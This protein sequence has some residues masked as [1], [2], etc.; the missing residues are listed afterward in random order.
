M[1]RNYERHRF[2]DSLRDNERRAAESDRNPNV[3]IGTGW[4]PD[5]S[6]K[7]RVFRLTCALSDSQD[8]AIRS[9]KHE[10]GSIPLEAVWPILKDI[11]YDLGLFIGGGG[12]VGA[13]VG[14]VAATFATGG[15]G[16]VPGAVAG[17]YLGTQAGSLCM[18]FIGLEEVVFYL[19]KAL[20]NAAE[21]YKM[22][23][24]SA[25][26]GSPFAANDFADGHVLM[27]KAILAGIV[28]YLTAGKGKLPELLQ[29]IK[30]SKKLGPQFATWVEQN[31]KILINNAELQRPNFNS[32]N[33]CVGLCANSKA[34]Q[35]TEVKIVSDD[36][37]G[38]RG[39]TQKD[40]GPAMTPKQLVAEKAKM[41]KEMAI[42]A[43]EKENIKNLTRKA[44][45]R[46][47][48]DDKLK[49]Y[50]LNPDHPLGASKAKWFDEA[51]EFNIKNSDKLAEQIVFNEASA[52]KTEVIEQGVK[53]NQVIPIQGANNKVI[54]VKFGWIRNN[55]GVVRLI[56]AIPTKK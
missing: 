44:A 1:P 5:T 52:V 39:V 37:F 9:L 15:V 7:G 47:S 32:R 23:F 41:E 10:L 38:H 50:L 28:F 30:A 53:F 2:I 26:S 6:I 46:A 31:E 24:N 20:P 33:K 45:T 16:A 51:L 25:M 49:R 21:Y 13:V 12:A 35:K 8:K 27:V 19:F 43:A 22:G 54:D 56:T 4:R 18:V 34:Q 36:D 3:Y 29:K 55:D 42:E 14:A 40:T 11:C 17:A 48:V